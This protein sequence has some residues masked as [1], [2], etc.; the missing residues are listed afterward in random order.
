VDGK[1]TIP[2]GPGWGGEINPAWLDRA[3]YQRSALD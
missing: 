3:S 1:A 2:A